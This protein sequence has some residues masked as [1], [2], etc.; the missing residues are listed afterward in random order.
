MERETLHCCEDIKTNEDLHFICEEGT[1][2]WKE[3]KLTQG[4][5]PYLQ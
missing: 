1:S 5:G 3:L 2:S 4:L